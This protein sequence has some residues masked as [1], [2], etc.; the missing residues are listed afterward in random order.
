MSFMLNALNGSTQAEFVRYFNVID[1]S[2]LS[3]KSVSTDTFCKARIKLFHQAFIELN[4]D[5][6]QAFYETTT[7][8]R[9]QGLKLLGVDGSVTQLPISDKLLEH[10]GKALPHAAMPHVRL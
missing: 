4:A 6:V 5:L 3:T 1:D 9:W 8:D 7:I 2:Y 10:F